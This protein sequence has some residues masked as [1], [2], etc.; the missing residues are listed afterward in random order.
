M[1]RIAK[2]TKKLDVLDV[3]NVEDS[4]NFNDALNQDIPMLGAAVII[5]DNAAGESGLSYI[6]AADGTVYGGISDTVCGSVELIIDYMN[7]YPNKMM[8]CR[9]TS[10]VSENGRDFLTIRFSEIKEA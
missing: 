8:S 2:I 9:L 4:V 3:I 7:L 10:K 5:E 1:K 6:F